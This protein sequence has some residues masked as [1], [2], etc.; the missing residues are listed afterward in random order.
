M[1]NDV[2]QGDKQEEACTKIKKCLSRKPILKLPD[3]NREFI[4]QT[5]ASFQS[6]GGCLLQMHPVFYASKKLISREQNYSVPCYRYLF[7][8][9]F[10]LDHFTIIVHWSISKLAIPR[11]L[12]N[13][14]EFGLQPYR[15]TVLNEGPKTWLQIT[16]VVQTEMI[17]VHVV[18]CDVQSQCI[19]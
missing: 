15:Y 19:Q 17:T 14:M 9:H 3:L 13:E 11:I 6:L 8:Q 7:G 10:T 2:I 5:D 18:H 1:P 12:D 16:S 4:L